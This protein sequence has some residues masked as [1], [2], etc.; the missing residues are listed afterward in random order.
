MQKKGFYPRRRRERS[1]EW[2]TVAPAAALAVP[3]ASHLP[4]LVLCSLLSHPPSSKPGR[5]AG[6]SD[7][8]GVLRGWFL[9]EMTDLLGVAA[10]LWGEESAFRVEG[11]GG[12]NFLPSDLG[13]DLTG[14]GT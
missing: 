6:D 14:D 8:G 10:R 9:T 1:Q 4:F 7:A 2:L 12:S 13:Q 11:L 5:Y 3:E